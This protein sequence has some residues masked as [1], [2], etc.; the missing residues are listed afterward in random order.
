MGMG[1]WT[2]KTWN[3]R[4]LDDTRPVPSMYALLGPINQP[5]TNKV[6]SLLVSFTFL[7]S[8]H[9]HLHILIYD[10][11]SVSST[12]L[13]KW[14]EIP[15]IVRCQLN[16]LANGASR[17]S[18]LGRFL[19][20]SICSCMIINGVLISR[21][22][23]RCWLTGLANARATKIITDGQFLWDRERQELRKIKRKC[24]SSI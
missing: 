3:W 18:N 19:L 9:I 7:S 12:Y 16:R 8:I 15:F 10:C 4:M 24:C 11:L 20:L 13:S 21:E 1:Q 2:C 14:I 6:P 17:H 23:E 22:R 5:D